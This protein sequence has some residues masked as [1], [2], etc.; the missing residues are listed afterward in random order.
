[1]ATII[2]ASSPAALARDTTPQNV[3]ASYNG[4]N[5][6]YRLL[7]METWGPA[8]LNLGD[9]PFRW[10]F[11]SL[12]VAVNL[13]WAQ[14]RLVMRSARL[15]QIQ[16]QHQVLD[17]ACGRGK[18]SFILHCMHPGATVLG[19]DL[20]P[21]NINVAETLFDQLPGLSY[22]TGDVCNMPF[23]DQSFDRILCLEAAFHFPDRAK[24]L[25][26]AF[27]VLRPGGRAVVVDFAWKT[28]AHRQH[29]DEPR[30]QLVRDVW[31]WEDFYS[32]S[33][34]QRAATDAGFRIAAQHDWSS[35]VTHPIQAVFRCLSD[36]GNNS[37]GRRFMEWR[38]PLYRSI[39]DADWKALAESVRG[40][41]H[42]QN[43]SN[44]MAFVLDKPL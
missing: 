16:P 8:L 44:Y 22:T 34:Y 18:S 36:L 28:D 40:H 15:M 43:N 2:E 19:M 30:T 14:R 29:R 27:R 9:Y 32:I 37:L 31:Q 38:N 20:L 4:S 10:P 12:N 3:H 41:Q 5:V 6:V 23:P 26:E 42:V 39:S 1:M 13:E 33:D 11:A 7:R 17:L 25:R 21:G 24:F 35:R